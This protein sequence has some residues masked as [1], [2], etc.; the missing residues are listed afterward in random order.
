MK[1]GKLFLLINS[2]CIALSIAGFS[3]TRVL[4]SHLYHLRNPDKIEWKDFKGARQKKIA[5]TF[6]SKTK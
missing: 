4:D 5:F 2:L 1:Q 6:Y 3:Q